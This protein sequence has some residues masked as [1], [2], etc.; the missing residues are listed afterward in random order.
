[1]VDKA[2]IL[3][4]EDDPGSQILVQRALT[5]AGFRVLIASRG[6]EGLDM[7]VKE[8]PNLI[9][10]DIN[11]P[12]L[13][14]R[15]V[16]T[17]LRSDE[18]FK[19]TPIVAL[20]ALSQAGEREKAL[21][22][23]AT[24]YLTKPVD[25]DNLP[26]QVTRY[27][28]GARDAATTEALMQAHTA[29]NQEIVSRLEAKIRELETTNADLRRLDKMKDD[30][31]QLTAHELR[32]PLTL[33]YGYSRL[34]QDSAVVRQMKEG[35]PELRSFIDGLVDSI[36]RMSG[37]INE[38]VTISRIATGRIELA[39]GP[40]NLSEVA[41][42]IVK[43]LSDVI[44][45]RNLTVN[46]NKNQFPNMVHADAELLTL[47]MQNVVGNAVKFTPDG[48]MINLMAKTG[49]TNVLIT[50]QDTGIGISKEDQHRIFER[51]YTTNS[52][53][54]H[55]TSKTAYRG[56]GLGL[57]LAICRGIIEAHGGRIWVESEGRDEERM[58]G[59]TFFI[60][61]PLHA[62][63]TSPRRITT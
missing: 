21:A 1:M 20:T 6:I 22:A 13:S 5:F 24:G 45:Q 14:G 12:D 11:L 9:L 59:S 23:G 18:R 36:D 34:L 15:E 55:S 44:N 43:N 29:Y 8:M 61:L 52:T 42:G 41:A 10:M 62:R 4:I 63:T 27:L 49:T 47:A 39:L 56:G 57:G 16:T 53:M 19:T 58:P 50:I 3:Y 38:I 17:R 28:N 7:A 31:I 30:F 60:D 35:N 26:Q 51:F 40:T 2:T 25:I 32:T 46:Y 37:I 54:L 33:V 48:G